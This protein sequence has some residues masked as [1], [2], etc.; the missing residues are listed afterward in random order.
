MA[1]TVTITMS[2]DDP[3]ARAILDLF[4][5]TPVIT[6]ATAR[7]RI[8]AAIPTDGSGISKAA[9]RN[10]ML[11]DGGPRPVGQTIANTLGVLKREGVLVLDGRLWRRAPKAARVKR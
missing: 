11:I 5:P 3:R 1:I 2:D 4:A 10:A 7:E 9:V 8:L 6:D